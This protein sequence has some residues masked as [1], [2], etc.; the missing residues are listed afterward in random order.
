MWI[1]GYGSIIWKPGFEYVD[2]RAGY[3]D[4]WVRRFYQHSTDHRGVPGEPGRVATVV[5]TEPIRAEEA[6]CWGAVYRVDPEVREEIVES[7]DHRERGGY[8]RHE[9]EVVT[10]DHEGIVE[11]A[12]MYVASRE[13][14]NWGGEASVSEIAEQIA[15]AEGPSGA[16]T[17]YVLELA[18]SLREIGASDSHVFELEREVLRRIRD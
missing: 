1:F 10:P 8:E 17:E 16:N 13:N 2:K 6:R 15:G 4:G 14:P 18:D 9:V 12:L 7:L 3:I 5:R 11:S